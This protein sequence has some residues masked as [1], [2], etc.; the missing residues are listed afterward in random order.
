MTYDLE[1]R[2]E[3]AFVSYLKTKVSGSVKIF[4][5]F[6]YSHSYP[7]AVVHVGSSSSLVPDS[8]WRDPRALSGAISVQTQYA[9]SLNDN[10]QVIEGAR[11]RH[12]AARASIMAALA[13]PDAEA[14]PDGLS[15]FV[16]TED[17]PTGLAARLCAM[18]TPGIF[19][20][21]AAIGE[22][23]RSVDDE[24]ALLISV[25]P[26]RCIAQSIEIGGV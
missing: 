22:M 23:E 15:G 1:E 3:D 2:L 17:M 25:I 6:M 24:R 14:T 18:L 10:A 7:C 21:F 16:Q 12:A 9:S 8:Q 26:F 5:S 11:E 20:K 13:V 19:I 4:A